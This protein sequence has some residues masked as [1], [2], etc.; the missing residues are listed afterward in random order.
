MG[1]VVTRVADELVV[2]PAVLPEYVGGS[3]KCPTPESKLSKS[4]CAWAPS[5][6]AMPNAAASAKTVL[7]ADDFVMA[8]LLWFDPGDGVL[9]G[10]NVL[11]IGSFYGLWS[12]HTPGSGC[13]C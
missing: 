2:M 12:W 6:A 10:S 1:A 4:I 5:G 13:G 11:F 3:L 9:G 7:R 8:V